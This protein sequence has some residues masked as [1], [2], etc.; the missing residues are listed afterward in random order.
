[1]S[2]S[3]RKDENLDKNLKAEKL[4]SNKSDNNSGH[5]SD[6]EYVQPEGTE[7]LS[8]EYQEKLDRIMS[9]PLVV[10][11]MK[12][13]PDKIEAGKEKID[14]IVSGLIMGTNGFYSAESGFPNKYQVV[15]SQT[16]PVLEIQYIDPITV[17]L[18]VSTVDAK[19]GVYDIS[20]SNSLGETLTGLRVLKVV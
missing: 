7:K 11:V 12:A 3:K 13:K 4:N 6:H 17:K 2:K 8:I 20:F 16:I 18:T 9:A 1:M 5:N 19:P 15:I 10:A 14:V